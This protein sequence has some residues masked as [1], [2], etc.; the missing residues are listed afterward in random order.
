MA[1][2][3]ASVTAT[4][5]SKLRPFWSHIVGAGR[6]NEGLRA[7]WQSHLKLAK[8]AC[9]FRYVRFHGL[10]HDDMHVL[11][12]INGRHVYNFQ[13]VDALFDAI[14]DIGVRPFVELGFCPS[15]IASEVGTVFWWKGNGSPPKNLDHWSDLVDATVRHWVTRYGIDEVRTWYFECWN[16][17]NLRPFFTGT[18]AQYYSLYEA[19]VKVIKNIDQD[20]RVG[21]PS[22]SNFVPD[23]RFDNELEDYEVQKKLKDMKDIDSLD[24]RP[25]W[26]EH[27]LRWCQSRSVPVDFV[28]CH[29]YPTDWALDTTGNM[30]KRVRELQATPRDLALLRKIV[31]ESAYPQAE[32]HL[33]EW[34]SSPS[35]RDHAHDEVPAAV[36][37]A[38]TMLAS[39]NLVDT[40]AYWTF[41]DVFEEEGCGLTPFHGGF[42]LI[43]LQGIPKP[44]FHAFRILR[45]L[46]SEVLY[47]D[48]DHGIITRDPTSGLVQVVLLH[49]PD[50]V[51]TSPPPAYMDRQA[52]V[53]LTFVGRSIKK[54]L[55]L[56][57][58]SPKA[59]FRSEILV[60]GGRGDPATAWR[61]LGSPA[62]LSRAKTRELTQYA[63]KLETKYFNAD[64]NGN[65][66][67]QEA[68]K[69][70]T[71]IRISQLRTAY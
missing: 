58:L 13:Y 65:L 3:Q 71:L 61:A 6:A 31:S 30:S 59:P 63:E 25:V 24:W 4:P 2:L 56:E 28:S 11:S 60:P 50:E 52:A 46:G 21:G 55:F 62:T 18:R 42:G 8:L 69:P 49:Y 57:G 33:T 9:G 23:S 51:K 7:D 40:I 35:S 36:F 12:E 41:T 19:T 48:D 66:V 47:R 29:P 5:I 64:E 45:N 39:L 15:L 16:E 10:Y 17:P 14:L 32:I 38:R 37:I 68:M 67:W 27:F 34:S 20:L 54:R 26:V 53:D 70:W 1:D 43:N 44:V 22:T